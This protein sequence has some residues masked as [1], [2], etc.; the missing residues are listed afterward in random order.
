MKKEAASPNE[1]VS[2]ECDQEDSV[3][4]MLEAVSYALAGEKHKQ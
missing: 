1:D 4:T 2:D 3:M